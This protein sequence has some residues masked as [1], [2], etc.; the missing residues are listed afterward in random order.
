MKN[1][2]IGDKAWMIEY[3]TDLPC[4]RGTR[5]ADLDKAIYKRFVYPT[6]EE[7]IFEAVKSSPLDCFRKVQYW[8]VQL[9]DPH[10]KGIR[11]TFKWE[12][13]GD[14]YEYSG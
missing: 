14:V 3:C 7:A 12:I 2:V 1:W 6:R 13:I 8:E 9:I 4:V 5:Y 10:S 11:S